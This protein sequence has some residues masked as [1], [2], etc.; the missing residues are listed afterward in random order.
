MHS[1]LVIWKTKMDSEAVEC[2][3][4]ELSKRCIAH[5]GLSDLSMKGK[6][7]AIYIAI[8]PATI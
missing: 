8:Q 4:E 7:V 5:L 6:Y 2:A 1:M 3:S